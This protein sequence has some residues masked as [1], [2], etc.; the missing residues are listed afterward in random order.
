MSWQFW[1]ALFA[2][3]TTLLGNASAQTKPSADV[4]VADFEAGRAVS[5][6]LKN[7]SARFG[8]GASA[9]DAAQGASFLRLTPK[10]PDA[11]KTYLQLPLPPDARLFAHERLTA[12]V[13]AA[14]ARPE[15]RLC[16]IALD[17][18]RHPVF[19]RQFK[20]GAG[21]M[22]VK[23]E[24]PLREWLWDTRRIA[25]ADEVK[26]IVLRIDSP[27]VAHVDVDDVR[28]A[29]HCEP[30]SETTWLLDLAFGAG[31]PRDVA[32][33]AGLM[34]ATEAV[35]AFADA[36]LNRLLDD[37]RRTRAFVR[38]AFGGA[39]RPTDDIARPACLLIFNDDEARAAFLER[40]GNAWNATIRTGKAQG[41]TV[42]DIATATYDAERGVRRPVY[43]HESTHAV[44]ARDL[45]LLTGNAKH[46]PLQEGIA[47]YVQLCRHPDSV[48]RGAFAR[49]FDDEVDPSGKGFFIPLEK[50]FA[51]RA[52]TEHYAQL[53]SVVAYLLEKDSAL[54][55]DL[56]KGLAEGS[57]AAEVLA[58][59]GPTWAELQDAWLAW[60][61]E[62]FERAPDT[63]VFAS[64]EEFR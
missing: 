16:W 23:L 58:R 52:D 5:L 25:D 30:G 38:R 22:W 43:V 48:D 32:T 42:Q 29:G 6:N 56:S 33:D 64:P 62:H 61:R 57:T 2:V 55:A 15:V 27:D 47:T 3:L 8:A 46:S 51:R 31:K 1:V 21:E 11:G 13:R 9:G 50:L 19:Q 17:E 60:G 39:V 28:L 35:E 54:L 45:R 36:D 14:G 7:G 4:S 44:V 37:M 20:L 41:F 24:L 34:V 40:L 10:T 18:D 63:T 12:H 49:S 53:A 26:Y 59:R